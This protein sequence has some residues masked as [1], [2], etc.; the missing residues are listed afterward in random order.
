MKNI[1]SLIILAITITS[2]NC[3]ETTTTY[4][5]SNEEKNIV[6]YSLNETVKWA[7]AVDTVNG[8][9]YNITDRYGDNGDNCNFIQNNTL[10]YYIKFT[11]FEYAIISTKIDNNTI[12]LGAGEHINEIIKPYFVRSINLESF[13]TIEF[14]G[15]TYHDAVL[16]KQSA[17]TGAPYGNMVFSKTNGIEFILFEDGSW[18]KRLEE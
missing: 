7:S 1:F 11:N 13:S 4:T 9:I 2:C 14:N 12:E 10:L 15:E 16:L 18:Y 3:K 6:P 5:L 8:Y 17:A